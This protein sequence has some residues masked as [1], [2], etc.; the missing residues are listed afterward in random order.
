MPPVFLGAFRKTL[1]GVV[2]RRSVRHSVGC[3]GSIV[4]GEGVNRP[5]G[6]AMLSLAEKIIF[7]AGKLFFALNAG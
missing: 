5:A 6:H 1:S 3:Y 7:V 4:H 2:R